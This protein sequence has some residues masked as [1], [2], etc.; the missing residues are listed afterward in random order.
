MEKIPEMIRK[1]TEN[2]SCTADSIGKS[3]SRVLLYPDMVLKI[4][5]VAENAQNESK[6]LTWLR[7]KLPVPEI[8]WAEESEGLQYLLM[9]RLPGEM[10]CSPSYMEEPQRLTKL[11]AEAL[12][13]LWQVD[14]TDCPSC[15]DLS[16]KL[17][18][19]RRNVEAGM[20]DTEDAEP[21]TYAEGG[22]PSPQALLVW[23]ENNRP[24]E[25]PVFSHG[26]LC[27]PN[28]FLQNGK[29]SGFL[30]LG[31][32][33]VSDPYQDIALCCRSLRHNFSGK[34]APAGISYPPYDSQMLFSELGILPDMDKIRYYALLDELF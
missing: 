33:G 23:L 10:A 5:P 15:C 30:D 19:A 32:A 29:V 11:L 26:D 16:Y 20:A 6:M 8:L 28:V 17:R 24:E 25:H 7:G 4:E 21:E 3:H 31:N 14:I 1:L 34:Y 27:L 2:R 12:H 9:T 22:F 13:Q 18:L